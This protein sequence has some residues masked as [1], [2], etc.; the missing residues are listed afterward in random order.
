[1]PTGHK[2]DTDKAIF[3]KDKQGDKFNPNWEI[4][5]GRTLFEMYMITGLNRVPVIS[6]SSYILGGV[7]V[8]EN[9]ELPFP[10]D[11]V[12]EG[13]IVDGSIVIERFQDK[14]GKQTA[15]Q[16]FLKGIIEASESKV[17]QLLKNKT[18]SSEIVHRI[19]T[20]NPQGNWNVVDVTNFG[21]TSQ[22]AIPATAQEKNAD[23]L[24]VF[25]NGVGIIQ[26]AQYTLRRLEEIESRVRKVTNNAVQLI[27]KGY[28]GNRQQTRNELEQE[29]DKLLVPKGVEILTVGSTNLVD[30]FHADYRI[31][32]PNLMMQYSMLI[33]E[34]SASESGVAR[35]MRMQPM[36]FYIK[37]QQDN[38]KK[39]YANNPFAKPIEVKFDRVVTIPPEEAQK[40]YDLLVA[41]KNDGVITQED[42]QTR[43]SKLL[44]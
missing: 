35:R 44:N 32:L 24:F 10:L 11:Q 15:P 17:V 28:T 7:S 42:F 26:P 25:P 4:L 14:N 5:T 41:M 2:L 34:D 9:A 23:S 30:Q 6:H 13:L 21:K 37:T 40:Q 18:D 38:L 22:K 1:M 33:M 29:S 36:L 27:I 8:P 20:K 39:I 19:F 3:P 31:L 43:A 12:T 16:E